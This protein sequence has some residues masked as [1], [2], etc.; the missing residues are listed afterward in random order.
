MG[1]DRV[2]V[3]SHGERVWHVGMAEMDLALSK[4]PLGPASARPELEIADRGSGKSSQVHW[5]LHTQRH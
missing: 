2:L 4:G 5:G 3:A 1:R